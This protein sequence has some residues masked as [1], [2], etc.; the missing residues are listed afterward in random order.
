[1]KI[2]EQ[3]RLAVTDFLAENPGSNPSRALQKRFFITRETVRRHLR[4]LED[5]GLIRM[6]GYGKGRIYF[7]T[8]SAATTPGIPSVKLS[9]KALT[10][11]G[12]DKIYQDMIEP[13]LANQVS[14]STLSRA[15]Y[16]VTECLNNVI[17]HSM[18]ENAEVTMKVIGSRQLHLTIEDD[19][20]GVFAN[21]KNHFQLR[22]M[23]EAAAELAKGRRTTDPSSHA[24]E[25]LFFSAR[26]ADFFAVDANGI[27]Y[28]YVESQD[29]WSLQKSSSSNVGSKLTFEFDLQSP[30]TNKSVFDS[31]TK[32]F[33]FQLKSSRIVNPY[34]LSLPKGNLISR[35]EAKKLLA[36]SENFESIIIDFKNVE[37]IGQGFA[38]EL[39]RVYCSRHPGVVL[40]VKNANEFIQRMISYV[41]GV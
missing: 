7:L 20:I 1:M 41:R 26:I 17:D 28:S 12:E 21:L 31:Y 11:A 39:F 38:D 6:E 15:H 35:S 33:K 16:V 40:E 2:T 18:A 10:E 24:G 19:G 34:V 30:K 27:T 14:S 37:S 9:R 29:D 23:F 3:F 25:G 32:D 8:V 5:D 22:D 13:V 4:K 36:G